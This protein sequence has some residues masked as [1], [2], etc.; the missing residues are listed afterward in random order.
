MTTNKLL[1]ELA[2]K[3]THGPWVRDE[4]ND[5]SVGVCGDEGYWE[6]Q[7]AGPAQFHDI[8]GKQA[9]ADAD[10]CAAAN[11][12]TVLALLDEIEALRKDAELYRALRAMHWYSSPLAVVLN[13]KEAVNPGSYCPSGNQ[14]DEILKEHM[15]E[16]QNPGEA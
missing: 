8:R 7:E 13:P 6:W 16:T 12:A 1:R 2:E 11:P 5:V 9:D 10:F 14:L 3:A 15:S 4:G